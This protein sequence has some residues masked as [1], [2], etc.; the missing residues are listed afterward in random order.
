MATTESTA[1]SPTWVWISVFAIAGMA[2][3]WLGDVVW[4]PR[5]GAIAVLACACLAIVH[6]VVRRKRGAAVDSAVVALLK[7]AGLGLLAWLFS[8]MAWLALEIGL[9]G[10]VRLMIEALAGLVVGGLAG[11]VAYWFAHRRP[12]I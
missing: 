9:G 5:T 11:G 6:R 3:G 2:A 10:R 1:V 8:L 7:A 12:G 4:S